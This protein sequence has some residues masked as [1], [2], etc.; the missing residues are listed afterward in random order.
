MVPGYNATCK[1]QSQV[2]NLF[3]EAG[4]LCKWPAK[5]PADDL[6]SLTYTHKLC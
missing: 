2:V 3:S 5:G 6:L 1:S 4:K